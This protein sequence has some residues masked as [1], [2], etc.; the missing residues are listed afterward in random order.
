MNVTSYK[1]AGLSPLEHLA[2]E[3]TLI[4]TWNQKSGLLLLY[5]NAPSIIIGRNQNPWREISPD[6]TVPVFRRT[7]GGGAVYHDEGNLNWTFI[8]PRQLHSQEIELQS[9]ADAVRTLGV[10]AA[11]GNRGGIFLKNGTGQDEGKISGTARRFGSRNMLHHGTLLISANLDKLRASLA[12]QLQTF[13]DASIASVPAHP[14]NLA[15]YVPGLDVET[16]IQSIS[17]FLT[18]QA[19]GDMPISFLDEKTRD[20]IE[21][22]IIRLNDPEWILGATPDFS[23]SISTAMSGAEF[24][25]SAGKIASITMKPADSNPYFHRIIESDLYK[26]FGRQFSFALL[27]EMKACMDLYQKK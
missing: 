13:D 15:D 6:C 4:E 12:S 20:M 2:L 24:R 19:P 8:I 3:N 1:V 25:V 23:L 5:V 21:L 18:G 17:R 22:E 16:A 10:S 26:F 27:D 11:P 7:S 9:I 14:V